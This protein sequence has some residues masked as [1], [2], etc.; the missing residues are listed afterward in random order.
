M[1]HQFRYLKEIR[2]KKTFEDICEALHE[3]N[4]IVKYEFEHY[5]LILCTS[6]NKHY[7]PKKPV[8]MKI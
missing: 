8:K 7:K 6:I 2:T 4:S 3:M 1:L 5:T